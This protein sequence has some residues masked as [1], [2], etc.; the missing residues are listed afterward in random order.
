[1]RQILLPVMLAVTNPLA[2]CSSGNV[3]APS[4]YAKVSPP[5]V[6]APYYDPYAAYGSTDATWRPPVYDRNGTIVKPADPTSQD[7][8][9]DYEAAE[10]A[11]G[12]AGGST[13]APPGT[14]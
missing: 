7:S 10:W 6:K 1:M 12:A 9:P 2:A 3:Q 8:R 11:T 13:S 4:A 14:F 5:P